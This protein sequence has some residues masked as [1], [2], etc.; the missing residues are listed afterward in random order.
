M[1]LYFSGAMHEIIS[2]A[3]CTDLPADLKN[4]N[5]SIKTGGCIAL[6]ESSKC[7]SRGF[8]IRHEESRLSELE[9]KYLHDKRQNY[10]VN[11]IRDC[12]ELETGPGVNIDVYWSRYSTDYSG[13]EKTIGITPV[14]ASDCP[15]VMD[16]MLMLTCMEI[17]LKFMKTRFAQGSPLREYMEYM[18]TF[19]TTGGPW[20]DVISQF[21][22]IQD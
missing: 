12:N 4:F 6:F 13:E 15:T 16:T 7:Y 2:S 5:G 11:S 1:N 8:V 18:E 9:S 14:A 22:V 19:P 17:A 20:S 3:N 10:N 21:T